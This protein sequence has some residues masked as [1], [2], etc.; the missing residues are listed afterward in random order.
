[1][2]DMAPRRGGP[3]ADGDYIVPATR[4]EHVASELRRL[5]KS[6]ALAPGSRLRQTDI[7]ERFKV[8][9][10]PVREAFTA[11][12]QEGLVRQDTHRGVVVFEPSK[13]ELIET[14][15]IRQVL[16]GFAARLAAGNLSADELGILKEIVAQM[17]D[18][19]PS[20]Y[21]E[22]DRA[23]HRRIYTAAR[24]PRLLEMIEQV[25][26]VAGSYI[27]G[28]LGQYDQSYRNQVQSEHEAIFSALVTEN[29]ALA[30]RLVRDHVRRNVTHI[31]SLLE[32]V[33]GLHQD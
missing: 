14:S 9:T 18:A 1:M 11:L 29:A 20:R 31:A 23:F 13:D 6:G 17:R 19:A 2:N 28:A 15:E 12:A 21:V 32:P 25:R 24:R 8:S 27:S 5:I 30:S 16:E 10:T 26:E 33:R 7:A 22:L 3:E 4:S